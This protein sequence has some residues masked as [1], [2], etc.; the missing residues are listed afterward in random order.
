MYV[1]GNG[2]KRSIKAISVPCVLTKQQGSKTQGC[3]CEISRTCSIEA[4]S[5]NYSFAYFL[6]Q[7]YI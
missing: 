2:W 7:L 5:K 4:P 1:S 3:V 6:I